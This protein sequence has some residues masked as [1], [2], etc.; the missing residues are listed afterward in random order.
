MDTNSTIK[1]FT[2]EHVPIVLEARFD[3]YTC[4]STGKE[5]VRLQDGPR[6][7]CLWF[8]NKKERWRQVC[9]GEEEVVV[10]M[11]PL[12]SLFLLSDSGK[13]EHAVPEDAE[14]QVVPSEERRPTIVSSLSCSF[15]S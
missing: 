13:N 2:V 11:V 7:F 15:S 6:I 12:L 10:V 14:D 9:Q 4:A 8:S 1:S 5:F 3:T